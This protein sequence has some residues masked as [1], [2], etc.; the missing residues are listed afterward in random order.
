ML[1][2]HIKAACGVINNHKHTYLVFGVLGFIKLFSRYSYA[3]GQSKIVESYKTS[4]E[5]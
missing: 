1:A 4:S 5:R 2:A 3:L